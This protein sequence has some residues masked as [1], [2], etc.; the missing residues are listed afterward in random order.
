MTTLE[1]LKDYCNDPA[2]VGALMLT[3]EWGCGKSFFITHDFAE[4]VKDQCIMVRISL[5]GIDT[6]GALHEA[7]KSAWLDSLMSNLEENDIKGKIGSWVEKNKERFLS[8]IGACGEKGSA[9]KQIADTI[10]IRDICPLKPIISDRAVI[11]IFDDIERTRLNQT[12]L[13]G[14]INDYCENQ[15]FHVIVVANEEK[16]ERNRKKAE[17]KQTDSSVQHV[18]VDN[19]YMEEFNEEIP[20]REIK[21]KAIQRTVAYRPNYEAIVQSIVESFALPNETHPDYTSYKNY[22]AMLSE[23]M[24]ELIGV[25]EAGIPLGNLE[26]S[27]LPK[28]VVEKVQSASPPHNLRS[29]KCAIHDFFRVYKVLSEYQIDKIEKYMYSFIMFVMAHKAGLKL[30]DDRYGCSFGDAAIVNMYP[31]F[32]KA[33]YMLS[34]ARKWVISGEWNEELLKAELQHI[35][36]SKK[37]V[38]PV[39]VVKN[40]LIIDIEEKDIQAGFSAV[41]KL[42]Y[43]GELD[44]N[45]YV[46]LIDN[47]FL[48]REYEYPLPEEIDWKKVTEG[49]QIRFQKMIDESTKE[50]TWRTID[51]SDEGRYLA[52]ERETY[53]LITNF[54]EGNKQAFALNQK[55][56]IDKMKECASEAFTVCSNKRFDVFD[57]EMAVVT[58][59]AFAHSCNAEK[60]GF[61]SD[62]NEMW[63]VRCKSNCDLRIEESIVGFKKLCALLSEMQKKFQEENLKISEGH[64]EK[65]LKI[66]NGLV[67]L[68]TAS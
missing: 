13:L 35:L 10:G 57:E 20:Y 31:V 52:E 18:F 63:T 62:F 7:T 22:R 54:R 32:Y 61:I 4:A 53:R 27:E 60:R 16:I 19:L 36:D 42:A 46:N 17:L 67:C 37:A 21:E 30:S 11:L 2:P 6:V 59:E 64:T 68:L 44:L 38:R 24:A 23:H 5:F 55:L 14:C 25:F 43:S 1:E 29:F 39:D 3:G 28:D 9:I 8:L 49:V 34:V 66:A 48:S 47:S 51:L 41:L 26:E 12:D 50:Y 58:V 65:F 15:H 40:S 33:T 56:Y 45:G